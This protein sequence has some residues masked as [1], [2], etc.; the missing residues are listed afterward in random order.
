MLVI[1]YKKIKE[2][3]CIYLYFKILGKKKLFEKFAFDEPAWNFFFN[4]EN[5]HVYT[6]YLFVH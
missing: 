2:Y 6:I 3:G 4:I 5:G 1:M